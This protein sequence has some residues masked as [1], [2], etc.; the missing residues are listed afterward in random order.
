MDLS[1]VAPNL[2]SPRFVNNQLVSLINSS[3]GTCTLIWH[4]VNFAYG[5]GSLLISQR[6]EVITLTPGPNKDTTLL[7]NL[8]PISL[9]NTD[10][11]ILT[12]VIE[13]SF[14]KSN[15]PGWNWV[16]KKR[17]IGENIRLI[18]DTEEN[19]IPRIALFIDFK[20]RFWYKF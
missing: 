12:K 15:K 4:V 8:R 17:Y 6:R 18:S 9:L 1:S 11:K 14:T 16:Y 5:N 7:D 3:G 19:N 20:K 10:Y 2:T 13:K